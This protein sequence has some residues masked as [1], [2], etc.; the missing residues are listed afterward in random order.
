MEV[1]SECSN[2][3]W[4]QLWYSDINLALP[5]SSAAVRWRGSRPNI[6]LTPRSHH[7]HLPCCPVAGCVALRVPLLLSQLVA[8]IPSAWVPHTLRLTLPTS[9][10]W[11]LSKLNT[12]GH[13]C[14]GT[15][16]TNVC[17]SRRYGN[18]GGEKHFPP[19]MRSTSQKRHHWQ[20]KTDPKE[21]KT[22]RQKRKVL[23]PLF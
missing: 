18:G 6:V 23:S 17:W 12:L 8:S 16:A 5:A 2:L 7:G 20:G 13:Y 14:T 4:Y 22:P 3:A 1:T 19:A 9:R 15:S 10:T 11:R 21:T